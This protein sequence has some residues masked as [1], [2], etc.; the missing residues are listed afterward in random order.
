[1]EERAVE[2][3]KGLRRVLIACTLGEW[4][5]AYSRRKYRGRRRRGDWDWGMGGRWKVCRNEPMKGASKHEVI[6]DR[7]F[8]QPFCEI[9]L[10]Y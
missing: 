1:V 2:E 4:L 10:V 3:C 6:V 9:S 8:I 5:L 7:Q